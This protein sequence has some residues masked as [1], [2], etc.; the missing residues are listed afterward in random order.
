MV[1]SHVIVDFRRK[2]QRSGEG[3][4][5][6]KGIRRGRRNEEMGVSRWIEVENK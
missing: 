6:S 2:K 3:L 4:R 1:K 5:Q